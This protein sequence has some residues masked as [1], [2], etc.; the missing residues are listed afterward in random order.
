MNGGLCTLLIFFPSARFIIGKT[1]IAVID[2][3]TSMLGLVFLMNQSLENDD[4]DEGNHRVFPSSFVIVPEH[5]TGMISRASWQHPRAQPALPGS[6][7]PGGHNG[8][9]AG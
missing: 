8:V 9:I 2:N 5:I 7:H 6:T 3:P 4:D 1:I